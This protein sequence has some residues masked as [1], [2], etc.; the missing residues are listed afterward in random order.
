MLEGTETLERFKPMQMGA[1][2]SLRQLSLIR[3]LKS[4]ELYPKS[5]SLKGK[6]Q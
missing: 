6:M 3:V 4:Q 2:S 5:Q 1:V